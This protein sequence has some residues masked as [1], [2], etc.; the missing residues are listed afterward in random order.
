MPD[1]QGILVWSTRDP[2]KGKSTEEFTS[3]LAGSLSGRVDQAW[4]FGSL[5]TSKF[6]PESDID[7][8][9]VVK[10]EKPFLERARDFFDVMDLALAMDLLVYTPEEFERLTTDPEPGFWTSVVGSMRRVV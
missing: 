1:T 4:I 5:G 9:L 6:G 10:T 8:I 7:L 3:T 2:L